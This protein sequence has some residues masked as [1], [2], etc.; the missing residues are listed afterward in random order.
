MRLQAPVLDLKKAK[1]EIPKIAIQANNKDC[2]NRFNKRQ[3]SITKSTLEGY[4]K[5][6]KR[7]DFLCK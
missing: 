4:K 6:N 2:L 5:M 7:Y 1:I 3:F